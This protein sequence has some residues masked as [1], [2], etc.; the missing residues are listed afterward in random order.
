MAATGAAKCAGMTR[1]NAQLVA[2]SSHPPPALRNVA[3]FCE[4]AVGQ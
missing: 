4:S 2:M 3:G 1:R